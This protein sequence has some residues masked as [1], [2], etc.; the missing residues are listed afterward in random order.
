MTDQTHASLKLKP[1]DRVRQP[2]TRKSGIIASDQLD[3]RV[4]VRVDGGHSEVWRV[5][6]TE[7]VS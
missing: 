6:D 4:V 7:L 3:G 5:A 2:S 1:G